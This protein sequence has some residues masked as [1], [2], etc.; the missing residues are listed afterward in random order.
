M[1]A[2]Q[3]RTARGLA[4]VALGGVALLFVALV[5]ELMAVGADQNATIS[6]ALWRVWAAQ[7]WVIF[8][9]SHSLAAPFWWLMGHFTGQSRVV[10]DAI[11]EGVDLD[12]ALREA[13]ER[14]KVA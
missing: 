5:I 7:P 2:A 4:L 1:N 3:K 14:R 9:V 10:Y 6:E 13:V 12:A 11:R 8:V